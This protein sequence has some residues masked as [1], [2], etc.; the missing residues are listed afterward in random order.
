MADL[1]ENEI[2]LLKKINGASFGHPEIKSDKEIELMKKLI[3]KGYLPQSDGDVEWCSKV[4][5]NVVTYYVELTQKGK[6][7][8]DSLSRDDA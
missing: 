1:S 4:I 3:D 6:D 2:S 7:F 8:L 5:D